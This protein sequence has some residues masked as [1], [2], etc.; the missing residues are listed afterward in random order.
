MAIY[1][2]KENR[3]YA[4]ELRK[5]M[6]DQERRLWYTF[7]RKH[8]TQFRRQKQFGPYIVDFYCSKAM[9][10]IEIDGGQHYSDESADY[11]QKR[12]DY[13]ESLGLK[14]LRFTNTEISRDLNSVCEVINREIK[15]R[16]LLSS[17]EETPE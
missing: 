2:K 9:L 13:L 5:N 3:E 16:I 10:V 11:E 15:A 8:E 12:T 6:T 4:K 1:Y 7:L 14:V 17:T